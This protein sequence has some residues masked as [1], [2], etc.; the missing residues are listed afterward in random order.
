MIDLHTHSTVSDGSSSPSELALMA[1]EKGLSVWALTDHD[2]VDGIKEAAQACS[3]T[4]LRFVPGVELAVQWKPSGEFHL[5]GYGISPDNDF[6]CSVLAGA[7]EE[8]IQR[9]DKIMSLFRANGIKIE[10]DAVK[11]RSG[12]NGIIGRPHF[13]RYLVETGVVKNIEQAFSRYLAV[14]KPCYVGRRN[15]SLE[16]A[17]SAVKQAGGIPVLAHPLSLYVSWGKMEQT[18]ACIRDSGVQGLEAWHPG[19]RVSDCVR[20]EKLA[21]QLGMFVTAGSDFHGA[22]RPDRKLGI[23]AGGKKIEDGFFFEGL[24]PLLENSGADFQF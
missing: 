21:G 16:E 17:V 7:A 8:R 19:A 1:L 2:S 23:T 4:G 13:A 18:L 24:E 11:K 9:N 3:G 5:L 10:L 15:L 12:K 22:A 14:N 20:L 6:L